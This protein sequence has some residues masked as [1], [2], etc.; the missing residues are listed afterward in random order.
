[1]VPNC[2]CL[3]IFLFFILFLFFLVSSR[4]DVRDQICSFPVSVGARHTLK[5]HVLLSSAHRSVQKRVLPCVSSLYHRKVITGSAPNPGLTRQPDRT[6][7]S[8]DVV[9]T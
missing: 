9:P 7:G 1:M 5:E 4:I 6:D 8:T 2:Q 3:G